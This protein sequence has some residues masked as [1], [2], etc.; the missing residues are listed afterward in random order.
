MS[1]ETNIWDIKIGS[2]LDQKKS[3]LVLKRELVLS[4]CA[5]F[6]RLNSMSYINK[7]EHHKS[8]KSNLYCFSYRLWPLELL[9]V[10]L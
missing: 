4:E 1:I 6:E 3:W 10:R 9:L 7:Y 5:T 2:R 8:Q